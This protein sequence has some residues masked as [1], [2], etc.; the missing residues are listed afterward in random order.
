MNE[1]VLSNV[2]SHRLEAL[3]STI[4]K[5]IKHFVAVGN[6]LAEINNSRLYREGHDSFAEYCQ[7]RWRFTAA[8]GRQLMGAAEA[9]A[10]LPEGSVAPTNAS[11]AQAL[12]KVSVGD[13]EEVWE[14]A[15]IMANSC[16]REVIARDIEVSNFHIENRRKEVDPFD[17]PVLKPE[18][19]L[20]IQNMKETEP[21]V[22]ALL[23][24]LKLASEA[25]ESLAQTSARE[26]LL[27]SGSA[28]MKH[29]RDARDHV[30]AAKPAGVCPNCHGESCKKCLDTGWVNASRLSTLKTK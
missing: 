30:N 27:T 29:I 8:R 13:R 2:E 16:F 28:L 11:Q 26:W 7:T 6:A 21:V 14:N 19:S 20:G 22:K 5:G 18:K 15:N 9:I 25:A 10:S 23:S 24:A 12:A 4:D 3:E 17:A 1:I